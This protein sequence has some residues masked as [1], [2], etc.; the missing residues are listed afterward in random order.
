MWGYWE[1]TSTDT[2]S[3]SSKVVAST[4]ETRVGSPRLMMLLNMTA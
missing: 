3:Q 2:T 1:T 4:V